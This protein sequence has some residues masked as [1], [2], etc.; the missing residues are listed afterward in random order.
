MTSEKNSS[1]II[2][3]YSHSFDT[4]IAQELG[5]N[6][7][8]I[9]NHIVYWIRIN[10]KKK[11]TEMIE[12][13]YWMYETMQEMANFFG[14]LKI[15]EIKKAIGKLLGAGLLIKG[16]F[17]KSHFDKTSWYAI[18]REDIQKTLTKVPNGTIDSALPHSLLY[19][20]EEQEKTIVCS[21]P[22][23]VAPPA[24]ENLSVKVIHNSSAV[25]E[26][27]GEE[28]TKC[29]KTHPDGQEIN[30]SLQDVYSMAIQKKTSW[31]PIEIA[32]A[33]D[34]L[35]KYK[36]PIRDPFRFVEGT[37]ENIRN[38][39]SSKTITKKT[40][41]KKCN[42]KKESSQKPESKQPKSESLDNAMSAQRFQEQ[43]SQ[44][45]LRTK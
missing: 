32:Q 24:S 4:G 12:G 13:R 16:N 45:G 8:I 9:Y 36:G 34:V 29:T 22:A 42:H 23:P 10:S 18:A 40:Q 30:I 31:R 19:T 7:A 35:V 25:N 15:D 43:L 20:I 27:E 28:I 3:G 11:N 17:N 1:E 39:E 38:S 2:S 6:A 21:E 41:E 37:I 14:Y 33:W 44:L 5:L 26:S